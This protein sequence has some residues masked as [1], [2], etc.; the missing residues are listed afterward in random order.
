MRKL[1][2]EITKESQANGDPEKL[3]DMLI[4][5]TPWDGFYSQPVFFVCSIND[6]NIH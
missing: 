3:V 1:K 4:E 2:D 6:C 5:A